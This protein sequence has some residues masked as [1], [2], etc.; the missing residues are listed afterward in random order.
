MA[1]DLMGLTFGGLWVD[2]GRSLREAA[3]MF[4]DTLWAL[5][6]GFALS[7]IVQAFV[8]RRAMSRQLGDH[9]PAAVARASFYGMVS[10]SCSYAASAMARSLFM[11]GADFLAAMVFMFASTNLVVE[12]G[13]VLA[14]L[15]GWQ[16]VAAEFV[17]GTIMIVLLVVLGGLWLRGRALAQAR[18][19]VEAHAGSGHGHGAEAALERDGWRRRMRTR[20]GWS[21][22]AGYTMSDLTMLRKELVVGF[23]AAGFLST[24]VPTWLWSDLFLRG[25][26]LWT[27]LEN[28]VVGPFVAVI[29]FVCSIGNVPLAAALW[30]GGITFGGV[31][32]FVFAD[33]IALPLLLIYRKQYGG[34]MAVRMLGLFWL[35]MSAAGL[36]TEYLFKAIGWIPTVKAGQVVGDTLRWNF[37]SVLDLIAL[38]AFAGLYCLYRNR[39]RFGGGIGYAR[40]PVCGMQV[41]QAHAP[42]VHVHGGR[43]VYFCSEH[44]Q[45]RFEADPDRYAGDDPKTGRRPRRDDDRPDLDTLD[46]V[47]GMTVD[48]TGAAARVDHGG[49]TVSFCSTGCADSF[50][51]HPDRYLPRRATDPIC[52]MTFSPADAAAFRPGPSGALWFCCTGCAE[53]WDVAAA[54]DAPGSIPVQLGVR[55]D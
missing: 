44:C 30:R 40:D 39:D 38:G 48:P 33:L 45:H 6:L 35:V 8:S 20:A 32:A 17:G 34:S 49:R 5:V 15:M 52:G 29:S 27:S 53:Q 7:G 41:D 50:Q 11:R 21:D 46:P 14:V 24:L 42:A 43:A 54:R 23:G 25:H 13:I 2:V 3:Y 36:A 16:F 18:A 47:C 51:A 19:R 12:L 37:T 22:A 1:A 55:R 4:W 26:G 31:V 28:A 10:S 9:R